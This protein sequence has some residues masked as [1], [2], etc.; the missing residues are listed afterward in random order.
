[1]RSASSAVAALL[2]SSHYNVHSRIELEDA[3]GA[4]VN[5]TS[6]VKFFQIGEGIDDSTEAGA[7]TFQREADV[8]GVR[9]SLAPLW[10]ASPLNRDGGGN[11]AP[12]ISP[13]RGI[14][15]WEA[16]TAPGAAPA[17]EDWKPIFEGLID[18]PDW[19]GAA[20]EVRTPMRGG[21]GRLMDAQ[22]ENVVPYASA[23]LETIAQSLLTD[24]GFGTVTLHVPEPSDWQL[25]A[26]RQPVGS[27]GDAIWQKALQ[28]GWVAR[29]RWLPDDTYRFSLYDPVR[30]TDVVDREVP[31]G[32]IL[33]DGIKRLTLNGT[34]VRNAV[35]VWYRDAATGSMQFVDWED[36]GSIAVFKRRWMQLAGEAV[37]N[38]RTKEEADRM[39]QAALADTSIPLADFEVALLPDYRIQL[40]DVLEFPLVPGHFDETQRWGVVAIRQERGGQWGARTG[41]TFVTVRGA[42]AGTYRRWIKAAGRGVGGS[43]LPAPRIG[44]L[45]GESSPNGGTTDDGGV[46][47]DI[48]FDRNTEA[49]WVYAETGPESPLPSP[50]L[51]ANSLS[52]IIKRQEGEHASAEQWEMKHFMATTP[53]YFKKI[54]AFGIGFD[55]SRGL[56]IMLEAQA[57]DAIEVTLADT[58]DVVVT[59]ALDT[60]Q[61]AWTAPPQ[62]SPEP[63]V[64]LVRRN[65]FIIAVVPHV[66]GAMT[67][68]DAGVLMEMDYDYEV[69]PWSGGISG[70]AAV[71]ITPSFPP[72]ETDPIN[73]RPYFTDGTP[74]L[75]SSIHTSSL[76]MN[77]AYRCDDPAVAYIELQQYV[78]GAWSFFD[79]HNR[80]N[81][82]MTGSFQTVAANL[83]EQWRLVSLDAALVP[84]AY[85]NIGYLDHGDFDV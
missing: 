56:P 21:G 76:L 74:K 1:M 49:I 79:R 29:Y 53:E 14:R 4:W 71:T 72:P 9:L 32:H 46:W 41:R 12:L 66:E 19:G 54:Y 43:T 33:L 20:A 59:R 16:V 13:F 17:P 64:W 25:A 67:F 63:V 23:T 8:A 2:A 69:F 60:V 85:S 45:R 44:P 18:D 15:I 7:I 80:V 51:D 3:D 38:L 31:A 27:L 11:Y 65:G 75:V 28:R 35:R 24:N 22:I 68:T 39:A 77:A 57:V 52:A 34:G 81:T 40:G 62:V 82:P 47:L 61:L 36:A 50:A 10:I 30:S 70:G 42:P 78:G 37:A 83:S 5:V 6:W 73:V 58:S 55:G 26:F 48:R 84:L